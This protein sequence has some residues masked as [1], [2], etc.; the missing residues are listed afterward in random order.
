MGY[1]MIEFADETPE[2]ERINELFTDENLDAH[3]RECEFDRETVKVEPVK[4]AG[5]DAQLSLF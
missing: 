4:A 2:T 3:R 5:S 1:T